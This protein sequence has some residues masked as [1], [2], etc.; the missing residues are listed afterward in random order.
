MTPEVGLPIPLPP[1]PVPVWLQW[2]AIWGLGAGAFTALWV[3]AKRVV[4]GAS[5]SWT[6]TQTVLLAPA[7]EDIDE[8][9]EDVKAIMDQLTS[10]NGGSIREQVNGTRSELREHVAASDRE[11]EKLNGWLLKLDP[12]GP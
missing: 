6:R 7:R 11:H 5:W 10:E 9:K 12:E 8:L 1:I 4:E 2:V 3:F